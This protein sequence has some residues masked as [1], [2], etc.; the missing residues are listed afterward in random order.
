[1][2]RLF[3]GLATDDP[4]TQPVAN[5]VQCRILTHTPHCD[6]LQP[7]VTD[8]SVTGVSRTQVFDGNSLQLKPP[9]PRAPKRAKTEPESVAASSS[10]AAAPLRGRTDAPLN[11]RADRIRVVGYLGQLL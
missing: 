4:T 10:S 3:G 1:M 7:D 5:R 11:K 6:Q 2:R 9:K 8:L